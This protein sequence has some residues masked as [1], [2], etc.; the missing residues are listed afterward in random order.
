MKIVPPTICFGKK[1]QKILEERDL[2]DNNYLNNVLLKQR[3]TL[4]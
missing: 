3:Q 4:D 1:R 2:F